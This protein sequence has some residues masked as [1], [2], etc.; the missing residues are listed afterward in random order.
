MR[1]VEAG[2]LAGLDS[3]HLPSDDYLIAEAAGEPLAAVGIQT[4]AVAA[5][6][7]RRT[8]EAVELLR[9]RAERV[10]CAGDTCP[11][12]PGPLRRL[13]ATA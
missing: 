10:G 7:F 8:A 6:P 12:G 13:R 9:L 1:P 5:T 11:T 4:G 2:R 3:T